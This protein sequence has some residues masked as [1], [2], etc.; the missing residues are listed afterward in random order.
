MHNYEYEMREAAEFHRQMSAADKGS[1]SERKEACKAFSE[2]MRDPELVAERISWLL[3]GNY[4]YG[5]MQAAKRAVANKRMNRAAVL[6]HMIG[7]I[8]WQCPARMAAQAWKK[9]SRDEQK[10]L[11]KAICAEIKQSESAV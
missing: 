6:T 4:G 11:D 8:E 2:A 7:A 9:L 3:D 5:A 10:A 1:L